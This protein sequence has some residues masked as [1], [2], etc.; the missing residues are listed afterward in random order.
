M[1]SIALLS[2]CRDQAQIFGEAVQRLH[3]ASGANRQPR[4]G[5]R[6]AQPPAEVPKGFGSLALPRQESLR[7]AAAQLALTVAPAP[8]RAAEHLEPAAANQQASPQVLQ[9]A[10]AALE[11]TVGPA[12]AP[13]TAALA[14]AAAVV[15]IVVAAAKQ[16]VE[17]Q[18][19]PRAAAAAVEQRVEQ[20]A[21]VRE[22]AAAEQL[23]VQF[24]VP[25]TS[26]RVSR[27]QQ[28]SL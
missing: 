15:A 27:R 8:Q 20:P 2:A 5:C 6:S 26:T 18:A 19:L 13:A 23:A 24:P 1:A 25:A 28:F 14:R 12:A 17:Q 21:P 7:A 10:D 9:R 16:R 22:P 11:T 3:P 4:P